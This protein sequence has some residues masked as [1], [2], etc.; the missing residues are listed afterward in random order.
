MTDREI[1]LQMG[2]ELNCAVRI[3]DHD[4]ER[5]ALDKGITVR[6]DED[7]N[8]AELH[9]YGYDIKTMPE[10]AAKLKKLWYLTL[11]KTGIDMLPEWIQDFP[12]LEILNFSSTLIPEIPEW[13]RNRPDRKLPYLRRVEARNIGLKIY[14]DYL[15]KIVDEK[16]SIIKYLGDCEDVAIPPEIDGFPV[17]NFDTY[18]SDRTFSGCPNLKSVTFPEGIESLS[19]LFWDCESLQTINIPASAADM[20]IHIG[21]CPSLARL[22]VHQDNPNY[23]DVDGVLFNKARTKL[24]YV[25]QGHP[26]AKTEHYAIPEGVTKIHYRA[27]CDCVFTSVTIPESMNAI[28]LKNCRHLERVTLHDSVTEISGFEGCESL[29]TLHIP[30][31]TTKIMLST[32][33]FDG[34]E[35]LRLITVDDNNPEYSSHDGAL[36]NKDKTI[37]LYV[38]HGLVGHEYHESMTEIGPCAYR[39]DK[40]I[41]KLF[42]PASVTNVDVDT[43]LNCSSLECITVD[44]NNPEYSDI[45]GVLFTKCKKGLAYYPHGKPDEYTVPDGV[46]VIGDMAFAFGSLTKIILPD[47]LTTIGSMAFW[48]CPLTDID[49]PDSVTDIACDAFMFCEKFTEEALERVRKVNPDAWVRARPENTI[50]VHAG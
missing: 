26:D 27:L 46:T 47:G 33:A 3:K 49:L 10:S 2:E 30:A 36:Y 23:T 21:Y 39:G 28:E 24:I 20:S 15:Y 34:C 29:E 14:S 1:V 17:A 35:A 13:L 50:T 37:L 4:E 22:N 41:K 25:P 45:D 11:H 16:V 19:L 31:G 5:T 43:F 8:V 6:C 40:N 18:F 7:G 42:L 38:P 44:E 48:E 12:E 32:G 9:F